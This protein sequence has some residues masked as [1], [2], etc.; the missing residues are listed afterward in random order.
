MSTLNIHSEGYKEAKQTRQFPPIR[1]A[2]HSQTPLE[3]GALEALVA[4]L[5]ELEVVTSGATPPPAVLLWDPGLGR[6]GAVPDHDGA[7]KILLL[8]E[9]VDDLPQ[10]LP[11]AGLFSREEAPA[12]LGVAIRQVARGQEYLSPPLALA[13]LKQQ[14][15]A[16]VAQ[17]R[18]DGVRL[19]VLTTREQEVLALL[20]EGLSN[21]EISARLYLSVRT[22]EGHLSNAYDKLGVHSRTEAA[23]LAARSQ[24]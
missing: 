24:K 16:A 17:D 7:T 15:T 20:G 12:S 3:Q 10:P 22:V 21:K 23:L 14:R 1:V 13:L 9:E 18:D 19:E 8:T 2:V 5:P 4:S 6:P 11:V